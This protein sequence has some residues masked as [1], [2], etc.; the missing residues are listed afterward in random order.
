MIR[1]LFVFC[2]LFAGVSTGPVQQT[3]PLIGVWD[4]DV[5]AGHKTAPD[6]TTSP[7]LSKG[8]FTFSQQGDSLVLSMMV[9]LTPN[10]DPIRLAAKATSD[11]VI[12]VRDSKAITAENFV[13][14]SKPMRSTFRFVAK[15]DSLHGN[16]TRSLDSADDP[17]A[18]TS[19][20][21]GTRRATK[22]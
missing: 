17:A 5:V 14:G 20:I 13:L 16:V 8:V 11:T 9:A 22:P 1:E 12:F 4:V 2:C 18:G 7:I 21:T 3:H 10:R 19:P 6:G 15:T